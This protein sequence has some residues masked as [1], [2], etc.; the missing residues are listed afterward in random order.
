M[1]GAMDS[2][3]VQLYIYYRVPPEHLR[4]VA[5]AAQAMQAAFRTRH[6]GLRCELLRRPGL[7]AG[8]ATLMEV[9]RCPSGIDDALAQAIA[10]AALALTALGA[11]PRRTEQFAPI[12]A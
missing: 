4:A 9:Y 12:E 2:G 1:A 5:S 10:D 8:Q 11:G 7:Q 3:P 6:P